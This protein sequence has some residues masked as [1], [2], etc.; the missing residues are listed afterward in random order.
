MWKWGSNE[1]ATF[2]VLKEKITFAPVLALL[3]NSCPFHIEADSLDFTTGV[4]LFQQSPRDD[5]WH[6]L[7]FLSKCYI[8]C[9]TL[10]KLHSF[11]FTIT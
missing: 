11:C 6:P 10:L 2:D 9:P 1:Q 3:E 7:A 4:V 8:F 5:K